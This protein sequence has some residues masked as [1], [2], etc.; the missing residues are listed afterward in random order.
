MTGEKFKHHVEQAALTQALRDLPPY[1]KVNIVKGDHAGQTAHKVKDGPKYMQVALIVT[2]MGVKLPK[3]Q[4]WK[5]P[6]T[7]LDSYDIKEY[8]RIDGSQSNERR[9][10]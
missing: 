8:K 7:C 1:S 3:P 5:Y 9:K 6:Y 4:I 10:I 2:H